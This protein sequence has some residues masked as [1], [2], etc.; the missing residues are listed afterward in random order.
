MGTNTQVPSDRHHYYSA[1]TLSRRNEHLYQ[2]PSEL[3]V[4]SRLAN[5]T[6]GATVGG[7]GGGLGGNGTPVAVSGT[8]SR[9]DLTTGR[10][11]M[12]TT[13]PNI[14]NNS[15]LTTSTTS[16]PLPAGWIQQN[17]LGR[18]NDTSLMIKLMVVWIIRQWVVIMAL[19]VN[20][21]MVD[22]FGT[23]CES[24]RGSVRRLRS[25]CYSWR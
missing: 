14:A 13:T 18:L 7:G 19:V 10:T 8:M 20:F 17:A 22:Q 15:H 1:S 9:P 3:L 4:W 2:T 5:G 12:M 24:V 16:G 25:C 11:T 23:V 21:L 6:A